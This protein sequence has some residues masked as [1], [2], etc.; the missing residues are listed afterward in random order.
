[1]SRT[2]LFWKWR[3]IFYCWSSTTSYFLWFLGYN[4]SG[5]MLALPCISEGAVFKPE[6]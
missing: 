5:P 1:L 6:Y 4:S 3:H 2:H